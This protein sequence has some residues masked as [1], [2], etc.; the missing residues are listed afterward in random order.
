MGSLTPTCFLFYILVFGLQPEEEGAC[1]FREAAA[2]GGTGE[3]GALKSGGEMSTMSGAGSVGCSERSDS[4]DGL[5][6]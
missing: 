5:S 4:Q 6:N 2:G 3:A 1:L